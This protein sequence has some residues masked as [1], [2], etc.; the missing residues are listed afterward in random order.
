VLAAPRGQTDPHAPGRRPPMSIL[1][2]DDH[3]E[4]L[5]AME[6]VLAELGEDIVIAQSGR[7]ALRFLLL[8]TFAVILLDV[9]MPDLDG[10]ETSRLIRERESSRETPIIFITG[11]EQ[12]AF[13]VMRG[14]EMGA[15]DYMMKPIVPA[16]LRTKV[17]AFVQLARQR[18]ELE[19][20]NQRLLDISRGLQAAETKYRVLVEQLPAALCLY[21]TLLNDPDTPLYIGPQVETLLGVSPREWMD[22]PATWARMIHPDDRERVL[23]G[24]PRTP[25]PDGPRRWQA[26]YRMIARDG[27]NVWVRDEAL[28]QRD[29][30][31][32]RPVIQG[33]LTD[34]T[35]RIQNEELRAA[36]TRAEAA[37]VS[38]SRFLASMSHEL[39][40]PL[41]S[42]IGFSNL[43]LKN[44][45][46]GLREIDLTYVGKI[47][48]NGL[49]LL[50][51]IND[52][53]DLAKIEA[54]RMERGHSPVRLDVLVADVLEQFQG[55]QTG[56]HLTITPEVPPGCQ[57]LVTD[58]PRLRQILTNLVA[59][60]IKFTP[61]GRVIVRVVADPSGAPVRM[62]VEDTGIGITPEQMKR[63]FEA[64]EQGDD[65]TSRRYGGTGLGLTICR[66][67]A[68]F[69]G[70]R[71]E[72]RS[73]PGTGSVFTVAFGPAP[74]KEV[75]HG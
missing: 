72:A 38:K 53:L 21:Q 31:R 10:F 28:V 42:V 14:Y 56:D 50:S 45:D 12:S 3:R 27:R 48:T 20:A 4:A 43:L 65:G 13:Q 22:N 19:A 46:G 49:H 32:G 66:S 37:N 60:A 70:Y 7:D 75:A 30:D 2:V 1:I 29:P 8:K 36:K 62:E 55:P 68:Q 52:V 73:E 41:N 59:N 11:A 57:P 69:L 25:K 17:A 61:R 6:A 34:L 58:E 23:A 71:L 15:V 40:T 33:L 47:R 63:I 51:L 35:E 18:E 39:R 74:S 54:G 67:L 24:R 16:I 64:F 26:E 9:K 44:P 5:L